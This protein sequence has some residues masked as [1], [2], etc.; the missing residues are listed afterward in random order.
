[1]LDAITRTLVVSRRGLASDMVPD[2]VQQSSLCTDYINAYYQE[3]AWESRSDIIIDAEQNYMLSTNHTY[4]RSLEGIR[5]F[6]SDM[7]PN[8]A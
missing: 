7:V 2:M 8:I 5:R 1:M 6:T 3:W 4:A